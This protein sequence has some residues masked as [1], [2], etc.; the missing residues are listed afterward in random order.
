MS[1]TPT[2]ASKNMTGR[3]PL[4]ETKKGLAT[5]PKVPPEETRLSSQFLITANH[6]LH[7]DKIKPYWFYGVV[8]LPCLRL[9]LVWGCH[10]ILSWYLIL[11]HMVECW[12]FQ[13]EN[14]EVFNSLACF[15]YWVKIV[16]YTQRVHSNIVS[17]LSHLCLIITVDTFPEQSVS[18]NWNLTRT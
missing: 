2:S 10:K 1:T 5:A 13:E 12:V 7:R 8:L 18:V 9:I 11:E 6:C 4:G 3:V 17:H 16:N 15:A 14:P